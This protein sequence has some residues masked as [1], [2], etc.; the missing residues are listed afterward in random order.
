MEA[1]GW[2]ELIDIQYHGGEEAGEDLEGVCQ[3]GVALSEEVLITHGIFL[4]MIP[5]TLEFV[6]DDRF[7]RLQRRLPIHGLGVHQSRSTSSTTRR[8]VAETTPPPEIAGM[9]AA[10]PGRVDE[11]CKG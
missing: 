8:A 10:L 9:N 1:D 7:G 3:L 6:A 2:G 11:F 4:Q 5:E